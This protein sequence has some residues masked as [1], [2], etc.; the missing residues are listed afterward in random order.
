MEAP[1][2]ADATKGRRGESSH[3]ASGKKWKGSGK[4]GLYPPVSHRTRKMKECTSS[5]SR[6]KRK[7]D[8]HFPHGGKGRESSPSLS[9]GRRSS[10]LPEAVIVR[11][12]EKKK[13]RI[14]YPAKRE[15]KRR[16]RAS[17]AYMARRKKFPFVRAWGKKERG[18]SRVLPMLRIAAG[19]PQKKKRES[20]FS[21]NKKRGGKR[22][23]PRE[24]KKKKLPLPP[25][26][27]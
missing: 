11:R 27:L 24:K 25:L 4:R 1:I 14:S 9:P 8:H 15:G 16:S 3:H 18:G 2:L 23:L 19:H 6:V 13:K 17:V 21:L 22:T 5:S 26:P 7:K 10:T 20:T 12:R